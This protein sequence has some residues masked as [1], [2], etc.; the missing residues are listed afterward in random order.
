MNDEQGRR[1]N[2]A[3]RIFG[4]IISGI[5][6][7]FYVTKWLALLIVPGGGDD[8]ILVAIPVVDNKVKKASKEIIDKKEKNG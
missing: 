5:I 7:W 1:L 2:K 6:V 3:L 8:A 4:Y